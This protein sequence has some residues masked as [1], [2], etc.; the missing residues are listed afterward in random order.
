MVRLLLYMLLGYF[1]W[2]IYR[3]FTAQSRRRRND[4]SAAGGETPVKPDFSN[5]KDADFE[6]LPPDSQGKDHPPAV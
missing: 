1:L 4:G 6:E 2:R 3:V 5:V